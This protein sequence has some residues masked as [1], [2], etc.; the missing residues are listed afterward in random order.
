VKD[1]EYYNNIKKETMSE[2][3][4]KLGSE[5]M[6]YYREAWTDKDNR[7]LFDVWQE[8][9]TYWEGEANTQEYE[10]DPAC[11]TNIVHPHIEGQVVLMVDKEAA[12]EPY[13]IKPSA[14]TYLEP[15]RIMLEWIKENNNHKSKTDILAR[16]LLKYGSGI[17]RVLFNPDFLDGAGIP[18]YEPC[19]PAYV[20]FDPNVTNVY[21]INEGKYA[22]EVITKPI[23]WAKDVYGEKANAIMPGYNPIEDAQLFNENTKNS[24]NE[25]YIHVIIFIREKDELRF[26]EMSS[27]GVILYDSKNWKDYTETRAEKPYF[28]ND[29]RT[30]RPKFPYFIRPNYFREGC[31]YGKSDA[32]LLFDLQDQIND[33]DDQILSNA[34]IVG[35][36]QKWVNIS[37]GIDPE[38]WTNERG[39]VLPTNG[40]KEGAGYFTPPSINADIPNRRDRIVDRDK[41]VV[42]RFSDQMMGNRIR[43]VDSATEALSLQQSGMQAIDYKK[44]ILEDLYS[45][46]FEYCLLLAT[47][48]W[49]E[50]MYFYLVG[51]DE[52]TYFKAS[53]LNSIPKLIPPT[54][55]YLEAFRQNNPMASQPEYMELPDETGNAVTEKAMIGIKVR[56][57]AGLPQNKAFK[58]SAV[59][60]ARAIGDITPEEN[61]EYLKKEIGLDLSTQPQLTSQQNIQGVQVNNNHSLVQ[62]LTENG[63]PQ[64]PNSEAKGGIDAIGRA[65]R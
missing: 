1:R 55:S 24:N 35:N 19:H 58:Y 23:S 20:F 44:Q 7:K 64:R 27:C 56:M 38:M 22:G 59:K 65:M 36:P 40:G 21:H 11:N 53:V 2:D 10:D 30:G 43:G 48:Y 3:E 50:D 14:R 17:I 29:I 42:T 13:A 8:V 5:C 62:G 57:G 41:T 16:R 46:V 6:G 33:Y 47:Y 9:E 45:E 37:S 39:L 4:I 18:E 51:S 60:E 15:V 12:V 31:I 25:Q 32:E 52:Y 63:N 49:E 61:R 54:N 34:R 28:P 26:I